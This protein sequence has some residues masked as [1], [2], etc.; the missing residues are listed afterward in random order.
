[1]KCKFC[2]IEFDRPRIIF[3][4]FIFH[5]GSVW[6]NVSEEHVASIFRVEATFSSKTSAD[7]HQI[8]RRFIPEDRAVENLMIRICFDRASTILVRNPDPQLDKKLLKSSMVCQNSKRCVGAFSALRDDY[9][10]ISR[11]G[12]NKNGN[13]GF[14]TIHI[15]GLSLLLLALHFS[16]GRSLN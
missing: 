16:R 8:T 1:V 10:G 11:D 2:I 15:L 12:V 6:T 13:C 7:F 5:T 14:L 3:R 9:S 4:T